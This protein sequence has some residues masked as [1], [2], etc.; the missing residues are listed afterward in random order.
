[1]AFLAARPASHPLWVFFALPAVRPCVDAEA[2]SHCWQ[3]TNVSMER[4]MA[5]TKHLEST[6]AAWM[7]GIWAH[8]NS[9]WCS[10]DVEMRVRNLGYFW[11]QWRPRALWASLCSRSSSLVSCSCSSTCHRSSLINMRLATTPEVFIG[12]ASSW[13]CTL[14]SL[15]HF[16]QLNKDMADTADSPVKLKKQELFVILEQE[17]MSF[18]KRSFSTF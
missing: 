8:R 16:I 3:H 7:A 13:G 17:A 6:V 4:G 2:A 12:V 14:A 18:P 11:N 10:S 5:A 15:D 1:M 9:S